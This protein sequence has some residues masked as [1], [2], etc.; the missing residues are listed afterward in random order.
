MDL[1]GYL[2][3]NSKRDQF[4]QQLM[5]RVK[6]AGESREI[7]YERDAY[8]F[9][10]FDQGELAGVANLGNI[11]SEYDQLPQ[12]KREAYLGQ[13][14]RAI[15]AHHKSIPDEFP[16]AAPDI[17]PIVRNRAYLEIGS[18]EQRLRGEDS[19]EV[20]SIAVGD[21]LLAM[22]IFDLP[23]AMRTIDSARMEQWGR[24]TYELME[25]ALNNL[26]D[27][28]ASFTTIDDRVCVF[29]NGDHYDASRILLTERIRQ[30][31]VRGLPVALIPTRDCLIVTGDEDAIG[32][33]L[34]GELARRSLQDPRPISLT[35]CRLVEDEW[36]TWL[37]PRHHSQHAS[38]TELHLH[39]V[40]NEYRE[41]HEAIEA[42]FAQSGQEGFIANYYLYR[43]LKTRELHSYCV[44]PDCPHALLPKADVVVFMD[45]THMKPLASGSWDAVEAQL[46]SKMEDLNTFPPRYRVLGFPTA[47]ELRQIGSIPRFRL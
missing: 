27:L 33:E 47:E 1:L 3:G 14:T 36:E 7:R 18:L 20:S 28:N 24:T 39:G 46:G 38:L 17:L 31:D 35:P 9:T 40:S 13:I 25:L 41:Q 44:W 10:F 26:R 16:D 11:F 21:H 42:G 15:L 6:D 5:R 19:W 2:F 34:L 12:D 37:P 43:D 45:S 23:E 30:L 29:Q 32:L 8:Q 22:P 4:A